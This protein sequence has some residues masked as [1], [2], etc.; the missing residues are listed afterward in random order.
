MANHEPVLNMECVPNSSRYKYL[1][2]YNLGDYVSF[3]DK[4]LSLDYTPQITGV[5]EVYK[6]G[7]LELR[8]ILGNY[9][10]KRF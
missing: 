6:N 5:D 1:E 2:D 8:L 4:A 10:K 9:K 3:R 7:H